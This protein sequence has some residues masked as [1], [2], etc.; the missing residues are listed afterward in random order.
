MDISFKTL[1]LDEGI[2]MGNLSF[3][4]WLRDTFRVSWA[5]ALKKRGIDCC[6][7]A[8]SYDF[9]HILK[10]IIDVYDLTIGSEMTV[11]AARRGGPKTLTWLCGKAPAELK[12]LIDMAAT[13]N[14]L[15]NLEYLV[16]MDKKNNYA[17]MIMRIAINNNYVHML[18][19]MKKDERLPRQ[20]LLDNYLHAVLGGRLVSAKWLLE[21]LPSDA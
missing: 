19:W 8:I 21:N 14:R 20:F 3:L 6:Y 9:L 16:K 4:E 17:D 7:A 12:T 11:F 15:E 18:E 5:P 2:P 10:W 1:V 13:N